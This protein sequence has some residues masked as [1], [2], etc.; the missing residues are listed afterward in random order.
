MQ[1]WNVYGPT[2]TTIWSII[3]RVTSA[4]GPIPIGRPIANTQAFVL[5]G[6]RNPVP[7]GAVGELY[8]GGAG[9]ARGYLRRPELTQERFVESPF[10]AEA[11]LYRTGDLARWVPGPYLECL[12]RI[13]NQ[14]KVRGFRIE[15]GE[16][17][18]ALSNHEAIGQRVVVVREDSPGDK[19]LV[20]YFELRPGAVTNLADLRAHLAKALPDYMIPSTFVP[21]D[22]LP[23]TPK[24]DRKALPAPDGQHIQVHTEFVSPRD[25]FE[26]ALAHIWARVL[27]VK[28][29]GLRDNFFELGGHSFAA[30]RMLIEVRK[31][32]GKAI[33][34]ATLFE[35]S[36]V[37]SFAELLRRDGWTPSWAS[38]VPIQPIG[39]RSPLFL[40][41]GAEGNVLLYRQLTRYLEP[42]QPVY[43]LQSKGLNGDGSVNTTVED[44]AS[45]YIKE[46]ITVQP[47][48]PYFL[49]GYCMGGAIALEMAQQLTAMGE[50]VGLV[51]MLATYNY[52]VSRPFFMKGAV[53]FLQDLWFHGA[54]LVSI[55]REDGKKFLREKADTELERLRIR[56]HAAS[57]ALQAALKRKTHNS[58]PHLAVSKAND[59]AFC[60][61]VPR[62]YS[63]RVI[64]IRERGHFLGDSS[65]TL[66][67]DK[68]VPEGLEIRELPLR[69]K[70]MLVE[71]FCRVLA[72]TV[73][74]CLQNVPH[75]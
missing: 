66:G 29:V 46:I 30:V 50:T 69:P 34:L 42:E 20:A 47:R 4:D 21:M 39:Q 11:R 22:K 71:P 26:Q 17:E 48:G 75:Q 24:I 64:V 45:R 68:I 55:P 40:V 18:A 73:T 25:P 37:E 61:Y 1:L 35:A 57:H 60:R 67:W 14:V 70:G 36:T 2:E 3:H 8:L 19:R 27:K 51:I 38:L 15:L 13:D 43:G 28:R 59:Q 41:H 49:G 74:G 44:M 12:G 32:A 6:H 16:I 63:G 72:E 65:P 33:P 9:L 5:D 58:Y 56:L 31:L 62:P 52:A 10:E 54:N 53:H 7:S 23:L